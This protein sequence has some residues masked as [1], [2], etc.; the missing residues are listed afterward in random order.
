[1][2]NFINSVQFIFSCLFNDSVSNWDYS[3]NDWMT[4]HNEL[5]KMWKKALMA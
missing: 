1:M 4:L 3:I 5:E 2:L